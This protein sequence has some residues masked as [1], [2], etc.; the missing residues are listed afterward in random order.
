MASW[1]ETPSSPPLLPCGLISD[2]GVDAS[3]LLLLLSFPKGD[4]DDDEDVNCDGG[5]KETEACRKAA[6]VSS[7]RLLDAS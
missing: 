2:T 3:L 5:D 1:S 4:D 6:S 7:F